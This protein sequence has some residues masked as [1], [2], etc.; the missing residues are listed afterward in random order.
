MRYFFQSNLEQKDQHYTMS[1]PFNVWEVAKQRDIID[2]EVSIDGKQ[3][4]CKLMPKEKGNYEMYLEWEDVSSMELNR[5]HEVLLRIPGSLEQIEQ[6]SP[7]TSE[8]PIRHIDSI[9]LQRQEKDGLCGQ[10]C[11]AMLAGVSIEDVMQEMGYREWQATMGRML[12]A[13]K[14]YGINHADAIQFTQ[15]R[16]VTLP[17]C[18][19]IME[20]MGRYC[21]YL[22]YFDGNYYDSTL[23]IMQEYD[24]SEMQGYLEIVC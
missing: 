23:G 1:L 12:S 10:A 15:G 2:G 7:Y 21:H 14:H 17:K 24:Q 13:L 5:E 18:C 16:Q 3:M 9:Q 6:E 11:I 20:K 8:N 4:S 22:I 19:I